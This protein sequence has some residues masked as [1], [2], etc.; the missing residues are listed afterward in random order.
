MSRVVVDERSGGVAVVTLNRP[1]RLNA[2][3]TELLTAL[4]QAFARL[5]GRVAVL[6]GAGRAFC[7]GADLKARAA[8]SDE[9]WRADHGHVRRALAAVRGCPLPTIAA[10][11]GFALAGGLE[12]ALAC[13]LIVAARD[14][15]LGLPEVRRGIMPGAGATKALPP[16][17]GATRAKRLVFTG[18]PVDAETAAAW[19]LVAEL[20]APGAALERAL[21]LAT[22][23]A[24]NAPLA[25]QAAKRSLD[26]GDEL[27]AYGSV[28]G[29]DDQREGIRAFVEKR[30]PHFRGS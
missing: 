10:I 19:G 18:R 23:I 30:P 21:E 6:T 28:L 3:D 27:D 14:A 7:T 26:G 20:A 8:M 4:E 9:E 15:Q 2:L 1:D 22:E 13:D 25:V 12:L 29:S 24:D 16:I 5:P 11:E 17:V